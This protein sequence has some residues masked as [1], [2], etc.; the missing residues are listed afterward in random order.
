[1]NEHQA[2]NRIEHALALAREGGPPKLDEMIFMLDR[3]IAAIR[4]SMNAYLKTYGDSDIDFLPWGRKVLA[5]GALHE[6]LIRLNGD[7]DVKALIK[8]RLKDVSS[9][10]GVD[11]GADRRLAAA[12]GQDEYADDR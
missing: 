11:Q 1:M 10:R 8:K 2:A 5:L 6:F 9:K 3:E 4:S 7:D 12:G